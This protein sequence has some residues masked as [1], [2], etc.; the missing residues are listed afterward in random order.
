MIVGAAQPTWERL[1]DTD[2][3]D[4]LTARIAFGLPTSQS[5]E[6]FGVNVSDDLTS[7]GEAYLHT[8]QGGLTKLRVPFLGEL[9]RAGT[10]ASR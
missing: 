9:Y 3:F 8:Q 6:L 1:K 4:G 7:P 2:Y 10:S 5:S